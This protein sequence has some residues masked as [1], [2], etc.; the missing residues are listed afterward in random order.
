MH[1]GKCL[2]RRRTD[3]GLDKGWCL[4]WECGWRG[5]VAG[6]RGAVGFR[7]GLGLRGGRRQQDEWVQLGMAQSCEG[8]A[9]RLGR[10]CRVGRRWGGRGS[11]RHTARTEQ[12]GAPPLQRQNNLPTSPSCV[13][14][15]D[16]LAGGAS[17]AGINQRSEK[18]SLYLSAIAVRTCP[19]CSAGR[20]AQC[21]HTAEAA[22]VSRQP[23]NPNPGA[24]RS[25]PA[26]PLG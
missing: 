5:P 8:P 15:G 22:S 17:T 24:S 2:L 25:R 14:T 1:C 7:A 9:A 16:R 11:R 13:R 19:G 18:A 20:R 21:S 23:A 10:D 26:E 12:V 4:V 6:A 3:S